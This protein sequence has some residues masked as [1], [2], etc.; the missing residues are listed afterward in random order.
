MVNPTGK[1]GHARAVDWCVELNNLHTKIEHGGSGPN[2]TVERIIKESPLVQTY[3]SARQTIEKNFALTHLTTAH[4]DPDMTKTF[5]KVQKNITRTNP[6][7][8]TAGRT[9]AY[10]IPEQI[11]K[12]HEALP[13]GGTGDGGGEEGDVEGP[14]QSEDVLV[15]LV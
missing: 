8:I 15:E 13:S 6:H 4:A 5:V 12:G 1:I 2:Q 11:D 9:T 10:T 3:R 7:K 14:I